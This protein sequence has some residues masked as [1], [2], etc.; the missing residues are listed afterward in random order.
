VEDQYRRL[1][2]LLDA[3]GYDDD[4]SALRTA[5]ATR[6]RTNAEVTRRLA[7]GGDPVFQALRDQADDLDL[8]A[9]QVDGLPERFWRRP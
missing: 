1:H 3:Y 4:R 6:A 9:R 8:A 5:V 2:L 7:D